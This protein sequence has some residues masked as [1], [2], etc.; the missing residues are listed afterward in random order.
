M[1]S[2]IWPSMSSGF[3][4]DWGLSSRV[5]PM[6]PVASGLLL[7]GETVPGKPARFQLTGW[8]P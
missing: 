1:S 8:L 2:N 6:N 3:A 4:R 7:K 5:L